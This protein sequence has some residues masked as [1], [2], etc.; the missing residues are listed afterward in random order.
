MAGISRAS[1]SVRMALSPL[2][3]VRSIR[4]CAH[5]VHVDVRQ[6]VLPRMLE[7]MDG[8]SDPHH[9]HG[10]GH[11]HRHE[12]GTGTGTMVSTGTGPG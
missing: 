7:A 8:R 6:C 1:V 5:L 3:E 10:H 2:A 11:E 12:H 9:E 4:N